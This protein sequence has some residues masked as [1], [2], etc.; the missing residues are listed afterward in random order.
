MPLRSGKLVAES[1]GGMMPS[2]SLDKWKNTRSLALDE[3]E[4]AH[5]AVGGANRGRRYATQQ[6]NHAYAVLLASQFQG[7]CRDMYT[8]SVDHLVGAMVLPQSMEAIIRADLMRG[9]QLDRGNAQSSSLGADF[10]RLGVVHFWDTVKSNGQRNEKRKIYL[11]ELNAWRNAIAHQNFDPAKL[12][13]KAPIALAQVRR[14]RRACEGLA[15]ALDAVMRR[16]FCTL[17]GNNPW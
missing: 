17:T 15:V 3:I 12:N 10:A 4:A 6:V 13:G 2:N 7:F 11:D 1:W 14:Y 9:R 16:H 5:V 8:E